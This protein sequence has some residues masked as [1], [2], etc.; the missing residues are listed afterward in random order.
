MPAAG[1]TR[2]DPAALVAAAALVA[3]SLLLRAPVFE[4]AG[5]ARPHPM[6]LF[7]IDHAGSYSDIAHL[8]FRDRL[9]QHVVPYV[10]YRFE[11][12]VLTGAFVWLASLAGGTLGHYLL[13]S[14]VMMLCLALLTVWALGKVEGANPWVFALAAGARHLG[15]ALPG[16]GAAGCARAARGRTRPAVGRS[17]CGRLRRRHGR[18]QRTV[19]DRLA[20]RAGLMALLLPLHRRASS[21]RDDM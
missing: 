11:Y 18:G 9:W 13:A 21:A 19:C 10:D 12:P 4:Y 15:E 8:Y 20:R 16:G 1:S 6:N 2:A 5:P 14:A 7:L 17:N 3:L